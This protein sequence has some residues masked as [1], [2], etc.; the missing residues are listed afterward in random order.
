MRPGVGVEKNSFELD[1]TAVCFILRSAQHQSTWCTARE[2]GLCFPSDNSTVGC[3]EHNVLQFLLFL[4]RVID[5]YGWIKGG[6]FLNAP[7]FV[8]QDGHCW[9][10]VG[11]KSLSLPSFRG[12]PRIEDAQE[13]LCLLAP[14]KTAQSSCLL[15]IPV[16]RLTDE[17][18]FD[19]SVWE[20][21][22]LKRSRS[23]LPGLRNGGLS[24]C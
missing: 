15:H 23:E 1:R 8:R 19:K 17:V 2:F 5:G 3:T 22:K 7:G 20:R 18:G 12:C 4:L 6:G 16:S 9:K 10:Q 11:L 21:G 13:E 24:C 14:S